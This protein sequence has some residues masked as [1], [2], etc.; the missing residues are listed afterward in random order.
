MPEVLNKQRTE[1]SIPLPKLLIQLR[2]GDDRDASSRAAAE[3]VRRFQPLLRKYWAWHRLDEYRD[4]VQEVMVR[5]FAA[6]PHLREPDAFPGLFRRVV[7]GTASDALRRK[8]STGIEAVDIDSEELTTEFDESL[9]TAVIVR[10]YLELLPPREREVIY[11]LFFEDL[12]TTEVARDLNL[13]VGAVRMTKSRAVSR[14]RRVLLRS[15][16]NFG[17][18]DAL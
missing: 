15:E 4:F 17:E 12:D 10:S 7:I 13:S 5:L 9:A 14:L 6:L 3:I 11:L 16:K 8:R 1:E 18:N 2:D